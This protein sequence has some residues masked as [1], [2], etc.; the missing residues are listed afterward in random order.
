MSIPTEVN[1]HCFI[2]GQWVDGLGQEWI[3]YSSVDGQIVWHGSWA[4]SQQVELAIQSGC[5]AFEAWAQLTLEERT[6]YCKKFADIVSEGKEELAR[7]ISMETGKPLWE[8]RTE[9][10]S[11]IGKV[12]NSIDAIQQRRSTI[13]EVQGASVV[14]TRYRPHGVMLVL[15]PYN[16]PAHLPGAHIVP[17]L[18]AGNTIVFKPSE[19]SPGVGQWLVAAWEKAGLPIGVMNLLHGHAQVAIAAASSDSVAGVL[20]TGSFLAGASL[21]R[22]L[23]GKPEKVLAL[24]MGGNNP[25]V[26]HNT[27][28]YFAAA[29]TIILSAFITSGQRCT[30]ARRLIVSGKDTYQRLV[31]QL[32]ELIPK[33]KVGHPLDE[34]QPFMGPMIHS[35]A[36]DRMLDA[37]TELIAK[38]A[39]AIV[40]MRRVDLGKALL[41]PGLIAVDQAVLD[42]TE[43]FGP[44]LSVQM[45]T[46]LDEAIAMANNTRFGLA[47]GFIGDAEQDYQ[48]FVSR[49]RAGVINWNRQ[50]T[51]ASGRLPFGGI[52]LSGNHQP[53]GSFAADYCSYPIASIE[54][55]DL[56]E[57]KKPVPGLEALIENHVN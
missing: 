13:T 47:A 3:R 45:A 56:N 20:F 37:Q 39:A 41:S 2:D 57:G 46:D 27:S 11:V 25:L 32:T 18:L 24:E 31:D 23:A 1:G 36:A 9:V 51:G 52:G 15:G 7:L 16:L 53:S 17:A 55:H 14:A 10:V 48:H 30:C 4:D 8:A 35:L 38:G 50:T 49:V 43:H 34:P 40:E 6:Q 12:T 33:I 42:D 21:H 26:V 28:D 44:M 22:L 29:R 5:Q 19:H 54:S